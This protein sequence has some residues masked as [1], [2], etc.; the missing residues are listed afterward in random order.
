MN[1]SVDTEMCLERTSQKA[2][3]LQDVKKKT[4]PLNDLFSW[5]PSGTGNFFALLYK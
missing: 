1:V 2:K 5:L 4:D 3:Q